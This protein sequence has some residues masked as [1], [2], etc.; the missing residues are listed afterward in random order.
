VTFPAASTI[1]TDSGEYGLS[2][3]Q[4][5]ALFLPQ[6]I[7]VIAAAGAGVDLG[8]SLPTIYAWAAAVAGLLAVSPSWSRGID[9]AP[10]RS[11]PI[12][13]TRTDEL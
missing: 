2:S 1:F 3:S 6:V 5:G 4:Y 10:C 9:R 8:V 12:S 11:I 13:G 7:T